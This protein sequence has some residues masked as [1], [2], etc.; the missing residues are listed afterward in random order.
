MKAIPDDLDVLSGEAAGCLTWPRADTREL[1]GALEKS[2]RFH[3]WGLWGRSRDAT[4][5]LTW[6]RVDIAELWGALENSTLFQSWTLWGPLF[7]S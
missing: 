4:G 6:P 7:H 3:S 1:W 2:S 5:C